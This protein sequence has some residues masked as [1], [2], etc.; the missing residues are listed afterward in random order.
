M[1]A[2]ASMPIFVASTRMSLAIASIW[3]LT[4]SAD[5]GA[6]AIIS[7]VFCAVTAVMALTPYTWNAANAFRSAWMP[8]PP[9]ESLPAMVSACRMGSGRGAW[10]GRG[11]AEDQQELE[12]VHLRL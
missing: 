12:R 6:I 10:R 1:A 7:R 9:P 3:A 11:L 8:A 4:R 5:R 2:V